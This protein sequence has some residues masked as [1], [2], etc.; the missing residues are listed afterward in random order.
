MILAA[1][2]H[3]I[4]VLCLQ[5]HNQVNPVQAPWLPKSKFIEK[6]LQQKNMYYN[7]T[8]SLTWIISTGLALPDY[9]IPWDTHLLERT[10][11]SSPARNKDRHFE[12]GGGSCKLSA[13]WVWLEVH[14]T[15]LRQHEPRPFSCSKHNEVSYFLFDCSSGTATRRGS[16]MPWKGKQPQQSIEHSF[17]TNNRT[18]IFSREALLTM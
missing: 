3:C 15:A 9:L 18:E 7:F 5:I 12:K 10:I 17:T 8:R 6:Y 14:D 13:F 1:S 11:L 4:K 16:R 2:I